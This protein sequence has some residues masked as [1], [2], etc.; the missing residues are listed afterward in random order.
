MARRSADV[1]LNAFERERVNDEGP[2]NPTYPVFCFANPFTS[3]LPRAFG[4]TVWVAGASPLVVEGF[5]H[6]NSDVMDAFQYFYQ[7]GEPVARAPVGELEFDT[8]R[9]HHYWHFKQF[10]GYRLLDSDKAVQVRSRK[11]S[12]TA[13][14]RPTRSISPFPTPSGHQSSWDSRLLLAGQ[15]LIGRA[16]RSWVVSPRLGPPCSRGRRIDARSR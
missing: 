2:I 15:P 4:S 9:G 16:S 3:R 14:R 13:L 10:A 7:D 1:C 5:R 11:E 8:R 12:P 6:E